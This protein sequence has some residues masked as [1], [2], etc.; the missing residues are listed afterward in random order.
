MRKSMEK[1]L[2]CIVL[3]AMVAVFPALCADDV[4]VDAAGNYFL[5][6]GSA[7]KV[8]ERDFYWGGDKKSFDGIKV[9]SSMLLAGE[10][11]DIENC[12][13]GSSIRVAGNH[14]TVSNTKVSD[15][16]SA[17]GQYVTVESGS[18]MAAGMLAGRSVKFSG[19]AGSLMIAAAD[20]VLDGHVSGDVVVYAATVT[21]NAGCVIEGT[22]KV[23]SRDLPVV[24]SGARIG[25]T[26][27]EIEDD[28]DDAVNIVTKPVSLFSRILRVIWSVAGAGVVAMLL[29][30]V[31]P[32][33]MGN[34]AALLVKR[35]WQVPLS[36]FITLLALLPAFL[37][38]LILG[39][40]GVLVGISLIFLTLVLGFIAI[41]VIGA[42][43][44]FL[45]FPKWNP[46]LSALLGG[47]ALAL[48][49]K[50]PVLGTVIVIA[51]LFCMIGYAIQ[52]W[53]LARKTK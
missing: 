5:E 8:V 2:V 43:I 4:Y 6:E 12:F 33:T 50:I 30:L 40:N 31:F 38:L 32:K 52:G 25:R 46:I 19:E 20:V 44:A 22:L 3:L 21:V 27:F 42:N 47:A 49:T 39:G 36:G 9:G 23:S 53:Y 37:I 29:A 16:V 41:P 28:L 35:P 15:N 14:I 26:D 11:I 1:I 34:T 18:E 17:A 10:T 51:S 7:P 13:V 24:A 45:I 48:L